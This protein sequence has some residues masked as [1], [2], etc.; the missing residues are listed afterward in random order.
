MLKI[1]YAIA[2]LRFASSAPVNDNISFMNG[3]IQL[4]LHLNIGHDLRMV[5]NDFGSWGMDHGAA[6]FF[7]VKNT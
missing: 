4:K 7:L 3:D 1:S 5:L 2:Y 6:I